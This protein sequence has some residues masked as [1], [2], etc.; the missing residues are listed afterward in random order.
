M[1]PAL[2]YMMWIFINTSFEEGELFHVG[3]EIKAATCVGHAD[4]CGTKLG[5]A[6]TVACLQWQSK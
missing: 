4:R 2:I 5:L 6:F 3:S 1:S